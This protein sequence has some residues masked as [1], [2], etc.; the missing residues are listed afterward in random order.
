MTQ[1]EYYSV[2]IRIKPEDKKNLDA[3]RK[4]GRT[5]VGVLRSG[6]SFEL[7]YCD[8]FQPKGKGQNDVNLQR[9]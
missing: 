4:K 7:K 9:A 1:Q 6:I 3:L 5:V 8:G 2:N